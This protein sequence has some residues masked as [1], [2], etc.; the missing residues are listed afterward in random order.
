VDDDLGQAGNALQAGG[1]IKVGEQWFGALVAPESELLRVANQGENAVV[2]KQ[3]GQ[4]TAGDIS[5]TD[6][7]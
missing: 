3:P 7:Q 4:E 5:T 1:S 6:D 2:A